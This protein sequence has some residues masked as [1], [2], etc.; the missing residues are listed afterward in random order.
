[1][2]SYGKYLTALFG[3]TVLLFLVLLLYFRF[4]SDSEVR[5]GVVI[6]FVYFFGITSLIHHFTI[7]SLR[8]ENPRS[9]VYA[10]LGS[11]GAK[12]LFSLFY[13]AV[14]MLLFGGSEG[15]VEFA[16]IFILLYLIYSVYEVGVLFRL[17]KARKG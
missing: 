3:L 12:M 15:V 9:F 2:G 6:P 16:V 1:M 8:S 5:T 10:F 13:L 14:Y 11:L 7:R 4:Y 17:V